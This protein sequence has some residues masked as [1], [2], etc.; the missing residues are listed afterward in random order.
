MTDGAGEVAGTAPRAPRSRVLW[1]GSVV[2]VAA[3]GMAVMYAT[4]RSAP[5]AAR[6][7]DVAPAFRLSSLADADTM[8]DLDDFRGRPI[9]LN[10]WASWCTP[11][12]REM[13]AFARVYEDVRNEIAFLGVNHLDDRGAA[14]RLARETGVRYPSVFD[15]DGRVARLYLLRGMPST[16]FIS[17]RGRVVATRA[18]EMTEQELRRQIRDLLAA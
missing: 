2:A 1:L 11:C 17:A 10:F 9:V 18:G 6:G 5:T 16:V 15:P 14:S 8:I 4:S 12:R 7:G 3:V 13:P